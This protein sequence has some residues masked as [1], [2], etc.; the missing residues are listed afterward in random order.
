M[1][2]FR[3]K[4]KRAD[5]T[6]GV[7]Y[8]DS[9]LTALLNGSSQMITRENALKIPA[10]S[11]CV[12]L[13]AEKIAALPIKLFEKA[14]GEVNEV[15]GD[16]RI[17]LLNGDTGDTI[18]ATEMR[19]RWVVDYFLGK[20]SYTYIDSDVTGK[21]RGLY[22][23]DEQNIA[24]TSD[25]EPIFKKYTIL[26]NGKAYFPHQFLK[27]LRNTKGKGAGTSI[28]SESPVVMNILYNTMLFE[29]GSVLKGGNKK[30]FLKSETQQT[31]PSMD[32][33][34]EAWALM[35]SNSSDVQDNIVVLN[36][37]MDFKETSSTAVEMQL[38]EN[39]ATNST[40]ICK[41][42]CVP[43]EIFTGNATEQAETL[44]V[45]NAIMPVIN[46]IEAALDSDLLLE[47]EKATRYYAFDVR[48]LTR[49]STKQR[50]EAYEIGLRSNFLQLDQ[51]RKEEDMEP[52]GFNFIK[53]GLQDVLL[54]PKTS[55]IYTPNTNATADLSMQA[56]KIGE[57]KEELNVAPIENQL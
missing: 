13:I 32:A 4:E 9:L 46:T 34:K 49:G 15:E 27:I 12:N 31:K 44:F 43:P 3:K 57:E 1:G 36:A 16:S 45:K 7:S 26:C 42:F 14:G 48:E 29:N 28:I 41:L 38:N 24:I 55:K 20:G 47:K 6:S 22:Y 51:V 2:L 19:K 8:E 35:F 25:P 17:R 10:V 56:A 18:N 30:G 39:K 53:L 54:D 52:L 21:T 23:V 37:G 40:E 5:E 50:Y 33:I 11:A